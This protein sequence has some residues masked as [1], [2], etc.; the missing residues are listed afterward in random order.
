[1]HFSKK[2]APRG[3]STGKVNQA[4]VGGAILGG[5]A[6]G[7]LVL[8]LKEL[9]VIVIVGE[10]LKKPGQHSAI[11][12]FLGL[13]GILLFLKFLQE[14]GSVHR[15]IPP[16]INIGQIAVGTLIGVPLDGLSLHLSAGEVLAVGFPHLVFVGAENAGLSLES[17]SNPCGG[18]VN[19][20]DSVFFMVVISFSFLILFFREVC[21]S[22]SYWI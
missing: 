7:G 19:G 2:L 10:L 4:I 9:F 13:G 5:F 12:V 3:Q 20:N 14:L 1:M 11:G 6:L 22:R 16:H 17:L 15:D 8:V 21:A 18:F